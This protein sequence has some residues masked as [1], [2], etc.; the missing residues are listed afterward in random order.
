[1]NQTQVP[2]FSY[3]LDGYIEAKEYLIENNQIDN[4][5]K[6]NALCH[7][8]ALIEYANDLKSK[9]Q[10]NILSPSQHARF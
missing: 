8:F 10:N 1:M 5:K 9:E 7:S 2:P 4:V 3:T 6:E